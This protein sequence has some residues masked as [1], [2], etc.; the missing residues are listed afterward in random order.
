MKLGANE[1]KKLVALAALVVLAGYLAYTN[2]FSGPSIPA[3]RPAPLPTAVD[4]TAASIEAADAGSP[5]S[6][7]VAASRARSDEFHPVLHSKRPEDRI[8]TSKID[9]TLRLD[10]LAKLQDVGLPTGGR[11]PFKMGQQ[12]VKAEPLKGPEPIVPLKPKPA[13]TKTPPP[14][15]PPQPPPITL[16]YFGFTSASGASTKKAFFLDGDDI[17]IAKE[18]DTLKKR[19]RVVRISV[20]SVVMED[21][22]SKRQQTIPLTEEVG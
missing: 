5:T 18:G 7:R 14:P 15:G 1:P 19:Y 20:T 6:P 16:K 12:P 11:N 17:L 9:P 10:L 22:D 21:M 3:T 2:V 8:D 4:K 13:G